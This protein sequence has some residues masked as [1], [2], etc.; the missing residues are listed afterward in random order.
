MTTGMQGGSAQE[1]RGVPGRAGAHYTCLFPAFMK[2]FGSRF[3]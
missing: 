3:L 2:G 1:K